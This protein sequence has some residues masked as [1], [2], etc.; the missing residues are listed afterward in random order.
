MSMRFKRHIVL[1]ITA[2]LK[3]PN[4]KPKKQV[5]QTQTHFNLNLKCFHVENYCKL[6]QFFLELTQNCV[7]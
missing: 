1:W 5:A 2:S 7:C 4:R 3:R 6:K